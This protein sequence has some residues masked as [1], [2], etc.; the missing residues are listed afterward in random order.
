MLRWG[1]RTPAFEPV[2]DELCDRVDRWID[3][4]D[5]LPYDRGALLKLRRAIEYRRK[6]LGIL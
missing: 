3:D 5:R 6:R 1:V 2:L 4:L